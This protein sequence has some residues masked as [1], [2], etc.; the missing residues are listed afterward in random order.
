MCP[1][2]PNSSH[3]KIDAYLKSALDTSSSCGSRPSPFAAKRSATER[4]N[5]QLPDEYMRGVGCVPAVPECFLLW[6]API[7]HAKG[8]QQL[9]LLESLVSYKPRF[10][11]LP[12]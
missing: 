3:A 2:T 11:Y 1:H 7:Q 12:S 6:L 4:E 9:R 10:R 8:E 5:F